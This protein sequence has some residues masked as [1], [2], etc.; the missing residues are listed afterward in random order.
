MIIKKYEKRILAF[1]PAIKPARILAM[2]LARI[3]AKK[4]ARLHWRCISQII[5]TKL[6]L[7]CAFQG[8]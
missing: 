8:T 7:K 1:K 6:N 2:K 4:P 5:K 3:L